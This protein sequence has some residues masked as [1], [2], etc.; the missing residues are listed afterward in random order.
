MR[1][2][3]EEAFRRMLAR[4]KTL[5]VSGLNVCTAD[6]TRIDYVEIANGRVELCSGAT[7]KNG[8]EIHAFL[9][10]DDERRICEDIRRGLEGMAAKRK[11]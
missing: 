1:K 10:E 4:K 5:R 8:G 7:V 2:E 6:G 9:D 11:K 3:I